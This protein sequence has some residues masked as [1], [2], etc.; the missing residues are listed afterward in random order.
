MSTLVRYFELTEAEQK[1]ISPT[2]PYLPKPH[3]IHKFSSL[4]EI[5]TYLYLLRASL[6]YFIDSD[7]E[8]EVMS[9]HK[10]YCESPWLLICKPIAF[11]NRQ[12]KLKWQNE[13]YGK[14]CCFSEF[15]KE[16]LSRKVGKDK[17][18]KREAKP[19]DA[20]RIGVFYTKE[21]NSLGA[22]QKFNDTETHAWVAIYAKTLEGYQ[23]WIF[24]SDTQGG[25]PGAEEINIQDLKMG[26]QRHFIDYCQSKRNSTFNRVWFKGPSTENP[27]GN[28]LQRCM[29]FLH[30][31]LQSEL[32]I[33][34][35]WTPK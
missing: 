17:T 3:E 6:E 28:G 14:F 29:E 25:H 21:E 4:H 19:K 33:D 27:D 16:A 7:E 30:S 23:L 22:R 20:A 9:P 26:M 31:I 11:V 13:D 15:F 8:D 12:D 2:F 34:W 35:P 1:K 32:W 10:E 5:H 18:E 24:D